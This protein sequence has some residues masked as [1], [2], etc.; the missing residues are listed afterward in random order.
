MSMSKYLFLQSPAP[1]PSRR[2]AAFC[3]SKERSN[4]TNYTQ[5]IHDDFPNTILVVTNI[6]NCSQFLT[7]IKNKNILSRKYF[8]N[9]S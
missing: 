5:L 8:S 4:S 1:S 3:A 9:H 7:P 6:A 2:E